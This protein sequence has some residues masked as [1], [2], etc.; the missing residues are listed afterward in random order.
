MDSNLILPKKSKRRQ[1]GRALIIFAGFEN[2]QSEAFCF[3][4]GMALVFAGQS[5]FGQTNI[6]PGSS[7]SLAGTRFILHKG[8]L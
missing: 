3:S 8:H 5:F 6:L 4:K 1:K 7:G 2:F